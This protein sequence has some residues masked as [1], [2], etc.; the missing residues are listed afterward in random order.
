MK[1]SAVFLS[2][3]GLVILYVLQLS[4]AQTYVDENIILGR[5]T[6]NSIVVHVLAEEGTE[7]RSRALIRDA[8]RG[9]DR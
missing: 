3:S 5:P 7:Q 6:S 9:R 1:K 8:A 4:F 2:A